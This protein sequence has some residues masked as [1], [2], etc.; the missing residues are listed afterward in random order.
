MA[1]IRPI[2]RRDLV[3][4]ECEVTTP[5]GKNKSVDAKTVESDVIF[6]KDIGVGDDD[7]DDFENTDIYHKRGY[8]DLAIPVLNFFLAGPKAFILSKMLNADIY[9]IAMAKLVFDKRLNKPMLVS[10]LSKEDIYTKDIL[11]GGEYILYLIDHLDVSKKI[12]VYLNGIIVAVAKKDSNYKA[13]LKAD[14]TDW[15]HWTFTEGSGQFHVVDEYYVNMDID[16]D[17]EVFKE[18]LRDE[19]YKELENYNS[20]LTL[21]LAV[22]ENID[23]IRDQVLTFIEVT[24]KGDRP[25]FS[26]KSD[27]I[28]KAYDQI[29]RYNNELKEA[30]INRT[31]TFEMVRTQY[32][33][34][35]ESIKNLMVDKTN[36]Y[37]E[38]YKP[39]FVMLKSKKGFIRDKMQGVRFDY[40]GRAVIIVDPNMSVDTIGIPLSMAEHLME[41]QELKMY[42]TSESNKASLLKRANRPLR[43]DLARKALEDKYIVAGRQPTLYLLGLRGFRVKIVEGE[44]IVMNPLCT[45]AFNADFDGDQMHAEVPVG[46]DAQVE[47]RELMSVMNNIYL[48]RNGECHIAPRQEIIHGLWKASTI[49]PNEKSKH[50]D[51]NTDPRD[52]ATFIDDVCAQRINIYDTV[53]LWGRNETAGKAAIRVCMGAAC[54]NIRLGVTPITDDP[55]KMEKPVT[56]KFYKELF[57]TMAVRGRASLVDMINRTVRLG[58]AVTEIFAPSLNVLDHPDVSHLIKEFE[59]DIAEHEKYYNMGLETDEGFTTYYD[60]KYAELEN[61]VKE[62]LKLRMDPNNGFMEMVES[63]AR[64]NISNIMQMFGMKGRVMKNSTESFNAIIDHSLV[65]QLSSLEH[66]IT[67]YGGREGLID[68]SIQTY[69]PGYLARKM[70]HTAQGMMITELDCGTKEG[71]LIDFDFVKQF[72]NPAML[73]GDN[74]ADNRYVF[75][76]VTKL[77]KGRYVIGYEAMIRTDAEAA[78]VYKD[79]VAQVNSKDEIIIKKGLKMRSPVTCKNPCC[80]RCYGLDLCTNTVVVPGTPV[81]FLASGSI[82]EPGTQLTMKNFQL[83]GVAGVTNLTSSFDTISNYLHL[84][85]LRKDPA[86]PITYDF[87]APCEGYVETVSRGDGTKT[88]QIVQYTAKGKRKNKLQ[89]KVILYEDIEVKDYVKKG[90]SIQKI[91]GDLNM[92]EIIEYRTVEEAQRY[93]ILKLYDTFQKEVDVNSKHFEI[94]VAGMTFRLCRKGN[95]YFKV[96][97]FYTL[98]EYWAHNHDGCEFETVLKGLEDVPL[99]RNDLYSTIFM[100]DIK[101]GIDRAIITSGQDEMKLPITRY[102]FGLSTGM[103]SCVPGYV[104]SR[105]RT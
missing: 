8:I 56:E 79:C 12:Q 6:G 57:K 36:S 13:I 103:G 99:Y 90:D 33:S 55:S 5:L 82:G 39:L 2:N 43:V 49:K 67:A 68:K 30:I 80:V 3:D 38:Q 35:V 61:K 73:T 34:L 62:E 52:L 37:D 45:P 18:N 46:E 98:N 15:L 92:R 7:D 75:D 10:Q 42:K 65:R 41:I 54:K 63:K 102:S 78:Q 32:I 60:K 47:V 1:L 24:P 84:Y 66:F 50:Y 31:S 26:D 51:I 21:L 16:V 17:E 25:S 44:A 27:P 53:S 28:S 69:A 71:L 64:G 59:D 20:R 70:S 23:K 11:I 72:I 88:L 105:G 74:V 76:F 95:D 87:I 22:R 77:I 86:K 93:L 91:Q 94:V 19:V 81:G 9:S 29:V 101:K 104:E 58:F 97:R 100:E 96:G 85:N 48:P 14:K 4:T 40:S 83:G 89:T